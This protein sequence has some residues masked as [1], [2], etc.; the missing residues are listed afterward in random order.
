MYAALAALA[1]EALGVADAVGAE[2]A[3]GRAPGDESVAGTEQLLY[4]FDAEPLPQKNC[5]LVFCINFPFEPY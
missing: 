1:T 4:S 3:V 5:S 2:L